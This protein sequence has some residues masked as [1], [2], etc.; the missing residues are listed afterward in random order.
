MEKTYIIAY[1]NGGMCF[2]KRPESKVDEER[3]IWGDKIV[4][5]MTSEEFIRGMSYLL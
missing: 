1:R 4:F 5:I 2:M 3:K